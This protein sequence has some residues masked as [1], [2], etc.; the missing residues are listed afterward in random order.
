MAKVILSGAVGAA[1]GS[2]GGLTFSTGPFGPMMSAKSRGVNHESAAQL[3]IRAGFAAMSKRWA[4]VLTPAQQATW[5]ALAAA[6]QIHDSLGQLITLTGVQ[7]YIRLNGGLK[8]IGQPTID[9][10]PGALTAGTPGVI[11]V[12]ANATGPPSLTVST[13]VAPAGG[14]A[15]V[16]WSMHPVTIGKKAITKKLVIMKFFAPGAAGPYDILSEWNDHF[17]VLL[18]TAV[19]AAKV[20]FTEVATGFQGTQSINAG[21]CT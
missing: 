3:G 11:T 6:H 13:T 4:T 10:A 18:T 7:M 19:I 16:V 9:T 15:A 1:A 2:V 14:E 12:N 8:A 21:V 17:G 5:I 20:Q